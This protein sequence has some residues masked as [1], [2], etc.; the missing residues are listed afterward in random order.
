MRT[1]SQC[2]RSGGPYFHQQSIAAITAA[3][4]K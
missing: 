1:I 2:L 4:S 3:G